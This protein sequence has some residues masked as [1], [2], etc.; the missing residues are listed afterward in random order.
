M[1]LNQIVALAA[2]TTFQGQVRAAA[3]GYAGTALTAGSSTH[4]SADIKKWDL[5][6]STIADGCVANLTR[7]TWGVATT[8]GFA[9]V[10]N[11]SADNNDAA[12]NSAMVSQWARIA[13]VTAADLGQ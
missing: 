5:A 3:L 8:G 13:G 4:S 1:T 6:I 2:D 11:D 7:F 12:I 9:A 10:I